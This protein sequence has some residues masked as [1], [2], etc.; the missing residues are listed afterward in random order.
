MDK[1]YL[2]DYLQIMEHIVKKLEH[3]THAESDSIDRD[4]SDKFIIDLLESPL[5][6]DKLICTVN[7]YVKKY[8]INDNIVNWNLLRSFIKCVKKYKYSNHDFHV[9]L[10][11]ICIVLYKHVLFNNIRGKYLCID[12]YRLFLISYNKKYR[13]ICKDI[14]GRLLCLYS[15][16]PKRIRAHA[17]KILQIYLEQGIVDKYIDNKNILY[18]D[19]CIMFPD[20]VDEIN[21][22]LLINKLI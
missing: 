16:L 13:S 10:L 3:Y 5:I 17:K 1:Q 12:V 19:F 7:I 8:I 15:K 14:I 20:K 4:E 11:N 9:T 22:K 21:S 2:L 18:Q 6:N